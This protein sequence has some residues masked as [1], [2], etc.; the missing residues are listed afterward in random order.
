MHYLA[1]HPNG[2]LCGPGSNGATAPRVGAPMKEHM[3]RSLEQFQSVGRN[4][5]QI[6]PKGLI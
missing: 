3:T 1:L 6:D 2:E 4:L 5:I